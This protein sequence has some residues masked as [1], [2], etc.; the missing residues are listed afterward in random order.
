MK[1]FPTL[2]L[3]IGLLTPPTIAGKATTWTG[4][5]GSHL[6]NHWASDN[7]DLTS[8]TISSLKIHCKIDDPIGQSAPAAIDGDFAYYPTWSGSFIALNYKTCATLW[9]LNVTD[10]IEQYSPLT[11]YQSLINAAVSR[12]SAQIDPDLRVLFFGTQIHALLVAVDLDT[13]ALLATTQVNPHEL[14]VVTASPT[15]YDNTLFVGAASGE[16]NAAYSTNGTYPC[17]SFVGNAAAFRF[18]RVDTTAGK[19]TTLW[20]VTTI[21]AHLAPT[22]PPT[23]GVPATFG[24]A[25]AGVWGS[26]PSIDTARNQVFFATGN[27]YTTPQEYFHCGEPDAGKDCFPSYIW[28]ESVFALDVRTGHANWVRRLDELDA[29]TL[30]CGAEGLPRNETL[31][32]FPPGPDADFGMAPTIV[33]GAAGKGKD[34]LTVGQKSG[35][36]YGLE[37]DNGAVLWSVLTSP[38]SALAGLS[39]GV[40]ADGEKVYY[41]GINAGQHEWVLQP[42]NVTTVKNSV[43]GAAQASTGELLWQ[44]PVPDGAAS[45]VIPAVVGDLVLTGITGSFGFTSV[46]PGSLLAV[47]QK[48]GKVL[49]TQELEGPLQGGISVHGKYV[50]TGT[51]YRGGTEG[52]SFYVLKAN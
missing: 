45:L 27:T 7:H 23:P 19:F 4:W 32:P 39:W 20:N 14:A 21:P 1:L 6:N 46:G 51:G 31:C 12:T 5:G 41:T 37:A 3:A 40:A 47:S 43:I 36:L 11:P 48:T 28:Q 22:T 15:Y 25:G 44:V 35:V 38:G 29:W 8:Q 42:G 2:G 24:W 13:G 18:R 33:K 26:Q 17:C 49:W 34:L 52:G 30:I 16:E 10:L 50:F 9:T